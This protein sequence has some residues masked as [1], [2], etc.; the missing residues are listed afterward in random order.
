MQSIHSLFELAREYE[1]EINA[2][3]HAPDLKELNQMAEEESLPVLL[4]GD[5]ARLAR[6]VDDS[7]VHL[8]RKIGS[9]HASGIF[10]GFALNER[11]V[12]MGN[13]AA[14]HRKMG[15]VIFRFNDGTNIWVPVQGCNPHAVDDIVEDIPTLELV[16]DELVQDR[17]DLR[18]LAEMCTDEDL[19]DYSQLALVN[20]SIQYMRS[21][22]EILRAIYGTR[23]YYTH[24]TSSMF[25]EHPH[26][27]RFAVD[28]RSFFQVTEVVG[29]DEE[30]ERYT[31]GRQLCITTPSGG[32]NETANVMLSSR[33]KRAVEW[34]DNQ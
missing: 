29:V 10:A 15:A 25:I 7:V 28:E 6:S 18:L 13:V 32:W 34:A 9:E 4:L 16:H 20:A 23:A 11:T 12:R 1:F 5:E 2:G 8:G 21:P 24:G 30:G 31:Y 27:S 17:P 19:C 14:T 22:S 26:T 3:E 33:F